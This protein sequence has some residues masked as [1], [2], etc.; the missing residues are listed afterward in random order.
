[1]AEDWSI[2]V[3]KYVPDADADVIAG[4]VRY[5]GI[6]LQSRDAS[7]VS[8]TDAAE[9]GRVREKFLKKKLGLTASDEDLDNSIAAVGE[10]MKGDRTKNRVTVYYLLAEHFGK[11]G[12]FGKS[13][14]T[15]AKAEGTGAAALGAAGLAGGAAA[16]AGGLG[17]SRS[18]DNDVSP[19]Y[20]GNTGRETA[21]PLIGDHGVDEPVQK[22]GLMRWLPWLLLAAALLL[23]L[24]YLS[25]RGQGTPTPATETVPAATAEVAPPAD[26]APPAEGISPTDV[27]SP[28][29][30]P[31]IPTGA[32]V[33]TEVR[34]G[35]PA[36]NVY[37]D[38]G[39]ADVAP[40]FGA[41]AT[42][43]KTYLDGNAGSKL[44]VSGFNDK[45]GNAALNAELSKNRA[46]AVQ[47]A[48]V[49]AGVPAASIEL[50][51]PAE[52]TDAG[53]TNAEARRVEVVV[54]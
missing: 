32:G 26:G 15:T 38:T 44:A 39:K 35:K 3:R 29:A 49:A 48:L 13:T 25:M 43:L 18:P 2:D 5:C 34:D 21:Q 37:F 6:A 7:L 22:S 19:A 51:K 20:A 42:S 30:P 52:T 10:R 24:L 17:G 23:L 11:L 31:E 1:M 27:A 50:A 4:I 53:T 45:T 16:V 46:Q 9:T 14:A 41:A 8:F 54:K 12:I 33:T 36:V 40:A 47:A 28:S